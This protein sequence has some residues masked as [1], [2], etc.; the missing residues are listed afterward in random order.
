MKIKKTLASILAAVCAV[1]C[2]A[3]SVSAASSDG[4]YSTKYKTTY[5]N[6]SYTITVTEG[7]RGGISS[8]ISSTYLKGG[9]CVATS[10]TEGNKN[11]YMKETAT[12]TGGY[13]SQ[14]MS[15]TQLMASY[16]YG[17]R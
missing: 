4:Y 15:Y 9:K 6:G 13:Y 11:G 8:S 2:M 1:S 17:K 5:G 10:K 7:Y 3:V 16:Y 14:S 12:I